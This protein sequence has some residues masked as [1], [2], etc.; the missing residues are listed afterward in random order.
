M[1]RTSSLDAA[2]VL[3]NTSSLLYEVNEALA[4]LTVAVENLA[5]QLPPVIQVYR[6]D[7]DT[8]TASTMPS[9]TATPNMSNPTPAAPASASATMPTRIPTAAPAT[10]PPAV[11]VSVHILTP[12]EVADRI[13]HYP[14]ASSFYLVARGLQPGVYDTLAEASAYIGPTTGNP[15]VGL[16]LPPPVPEN[17]PSLMQG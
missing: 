7:P 1:A 2:I 4:R 15:R 16:R 5:I 12:A 17:Y 13:A 11:A 9:A 14:E 10:M 6:S 3:A 8:S